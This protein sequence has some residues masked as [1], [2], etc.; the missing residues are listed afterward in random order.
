M[1]EHSKTSIGE[2]YA[3]GLAPV[4][5]FGES[6][7]VRG[8][9]LD[10]KLCHFLASEGQATKDSE[11]DCAGRVLFLGLELSNKF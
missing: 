10:L 8:S 7:A 5:L 6:V 11:G 4:S 2:H 1:I 9:N 3:L